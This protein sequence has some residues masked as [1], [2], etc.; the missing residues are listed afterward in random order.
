M[1]A[2][3]GRAYST[4]SKLQVD[5]LRSFEQT[6]HVWGRKAGGLLQLAQRILKVVEH[7][8]V[9]PASY[10]P[11]LTVL[12]QHAALRDHAEVVQIICAAEAMRQASWG[13]T[14][15]QAGLHVEASAAP[16]LDTK[17]ADGCTALHHACREGHA[18]VV[19]VCLL[20]GSSG[21][22]PTLRGELLPLALAAQAGHCACAHQLLQ[23]QSQDV[24]SVD[25]RGRTSLMLACEQGHAPMVRLLLEARASPDVR[26]A[27]KGPC[28]TA[29]EYAKRASSFGSGQ[30][31]GL[32]C[33]RLLK[34]SWREKQRAAALAVAPAAAAAA[35]K[36]LY[37]NGT[38]AGGGR[39]VVWRR[40]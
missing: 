2:E 36:V 17:A 25:S 16:L 1:A 22:I 30:K 20:H 24:D 37:R 11:K 12:L 33:A 7:C 8:S 28:H 29:L 5:E 13:S 21:T 14:A 38:D 3:Q 23:S 31:G 34:L 4:Y 9:L 40:L 18:Q 15:G 10:A 39:V 32:D 27:D 19:H 35:A 26:S 6:C